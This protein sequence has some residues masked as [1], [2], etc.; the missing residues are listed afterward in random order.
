MGLNIWRSVFY[1]AKE[2]SRKRF[3][4]FANG[5]SIPKGILG[6]NYIMLH[7][8]IQQEWK[9]RSITT[10]MNVRVGLTEW[11]PSLKTLC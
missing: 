4:D 7:M 8:L 6:K 10:C 5:K 11:K 3:W 2:Y 9:G 1:L